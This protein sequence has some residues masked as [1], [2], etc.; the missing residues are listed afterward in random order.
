MSTTIINLRSGQSV[1]TT[2]NSAADLAGLINANAT[3]ETPQAMYECT[4]I[5]AGTQHHIRVDA[6]ESV[7]E[8]A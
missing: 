6:I 2:D 3:S 1:R 5:D 7:Y 8:Q 4:N